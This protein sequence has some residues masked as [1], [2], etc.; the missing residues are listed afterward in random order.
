MSIYRST[1][2]WRGPSKA[3]FECD[4]CG[5]YVYIDEECDICIWNARIAAAK[6][7]QEADS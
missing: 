3:Q 4:V 1:P 2:P 5:Y 6:A 7:E